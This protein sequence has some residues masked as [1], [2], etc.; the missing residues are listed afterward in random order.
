MD[1]TP[2]SQL[3]E[4]LERAKEATNRERPQIHWTPGFSKVVSRPPSGFQEQ[5][6][7]F[8]ETWCSQEKRAALRS[9]TRP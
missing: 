2:E 8:F 9:H 6:G 4:I 1:S 5:T 7:R 3:P